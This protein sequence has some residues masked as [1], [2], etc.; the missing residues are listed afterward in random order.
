VLHFTIHSYNIEI[1][2][3]PGHKGIYLRNWTAKNSVDIEVT[4][5]PS[6]YRE[7]DNCN[8]QK[9]SYNVDMVL[10]CD[11]PYVEIPP[12]VHMSYVFR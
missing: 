2:H 9:R 6:Q 7:L 12:M 5:T 10:S 4:I 11:A 3:K 8:E 1:E